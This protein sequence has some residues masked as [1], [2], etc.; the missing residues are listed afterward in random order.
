V[1]VAVL[2]PVKAP[3][4]YLAQTLDCVLGQ[5]PA[6]D[7]VVVVDDGSTPPLE[8][9]PDHAGRCLLVRGAAAGPAAARATGLAAAG[10]VDL[11]ALC[12]ADDVWESGKLEAQLAAL[13]R[14]PDA[15][16][17]FGT[18][19][20]VGVDDLP[21]GERWE[22]I[23]AGLHPAEALAPL[24]YERNP[25]PTSSVAIR[26]DA[27]ARAGGFD[28]PLRLAEDWD[29]WLR[30]VANG[31]S[32]VSVPEA[33]VRYRRHPG[34]LTADVAALA[35]CQVAMHERHAGL[36]GDETARRLRGRDLVALAR[37]RV[38]RRDWKG[39]RAAL[40]SARELDSAGV[41]E[42]VL[43]AAVAVPF[44]RRAL[45]RRSPYGG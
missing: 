33:R 4:L 32:F 22:E 39:A 9:H 11:V 16:L 26:A 2:V 5:E 40:R 41:A 45:G 6:P 21:T 31:E 36:V 13:E 29:L 38:R 24:L 15:A 7:V 19:T 28:T 17:A 37:G 44:V 12:D 8:L 35:E 42:R 34:G 25:I 14:H 43:A 10:E 27:L 23:P 18:A 3:A 20:I 1:R 30:L